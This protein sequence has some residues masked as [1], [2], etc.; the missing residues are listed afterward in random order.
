VYV[1]SHPLG[2]GTWSRAISDERW[3]PNPVSLSVRR[4]L[5]RR[6]ESLRIVVALAIMLLLPVTMFF[7]MRRWAW[8]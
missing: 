2:V 7:W 3:I 4:L 6:L 5:Q 1:G 8:M